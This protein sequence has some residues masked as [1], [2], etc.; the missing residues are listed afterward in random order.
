MHVPVYCNRGPDRGGVHPYGKTE[1]SW[2]N[3]LSA[4]WQSSGYALLQYRPSWAGTPTGRTII[5]RPR[6]RSLHYTP[7]LLYVI[8]GLTHYGKARPLSRGLASL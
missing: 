4:Y 3:S 6:R 8:A 1:S 5:V 7:A 2:Q